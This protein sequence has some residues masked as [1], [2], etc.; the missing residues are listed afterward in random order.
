MPEYILLKRIPCDL[1]TLDASVYIYSH[2]RPW[3][4][5]TLVLRNKLSSAEA[6]TYMHDFE[7]CI[8]ISAVNSWRCLHRLLAITI[9]MGVLRR[10]PVLP[11]KPHPG[12]CGARF[13][14]WQRSNGQNSISSSYISSTSST[15]DMSGCR[16][17][18]TIRGR[19][20]RMWLDK[21][22]LNIYG[23]QTEKRSWKDNKDARWKNK[24]R[25]KSD[26]L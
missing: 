15:S 19:T 10:P 26:F 23:T 16:W 20:P 14:Q 9:N 3:L 11:C 1:G 6:V 18:F 12:Y 2:S 24:R 4:Q 21:I 22:L 25:F 8:N 5:Q 13:T 7:L 17:K